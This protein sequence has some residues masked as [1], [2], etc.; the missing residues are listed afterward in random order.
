MGS[1]G[2]I[3]ELENAENMAA[4]LT[5]QCTVFDGYYNDQ[6][7]LKQIELDEET[8]WTCWNDIF[9]RV[10]ILYRCVEG[11]VKKAYG[12]EGE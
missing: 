2:L 12:R 10:G 5:A 9:E 7:G 4:K 1:E 6:F 8:F 3:Q 11:L